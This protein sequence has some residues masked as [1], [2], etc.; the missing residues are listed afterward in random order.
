MKTVLSPWMNFSPPPLEKEREDIE[1]AT[2]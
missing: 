1:A 2:S